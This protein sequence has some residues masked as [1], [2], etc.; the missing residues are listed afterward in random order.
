MLYSAFHKCIIQHLRI[1]RIYYT[2]SLT[3]ASTLAAYVQSVKWNYRKSFLGTMILIFW[4]FLIHTNVT[5]KTILDIWRFR[6][7]IHW[8]LEV[9]SIFYYNWR[10][11][12]LYMYMH[13]C[14]WEFAFDLWSRNNEFCISILGVQQNPNW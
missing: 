3:L 4:S 13:M 14:F 6:E 8:W 7:K 10:Y 11:S 9:I 2:I 12:L 5:L 1:L